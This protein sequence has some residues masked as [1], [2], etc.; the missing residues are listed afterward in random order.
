[1]DSTPEAVL[2]EANSKG[3]YGNLDHTAFLKMT[4]MFIKAFKAGH[5][6]VTVDPSEED[7][8]MF[9]RIH[10]VNTMGSDSSFPDNAWPLPENS[11]HISDNVYMIPFLSKPA[12]IYLN[13]GG[14]P[15]QM[16]APAGASKG[17]VPWTQGVQ[18]LTAS[19]DINGQAFN[20][21]GP[22]IVSQMQRYQGNVV[23]I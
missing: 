1:M 17:V 6:E 9:Y 11:S 7:V 3:Y 23:A 4:H 16:Q 13:S 18:T 8:F 15:W 10:P 19:R 2:M 22:A 21:T 14:T 20:K 12:T 5:E